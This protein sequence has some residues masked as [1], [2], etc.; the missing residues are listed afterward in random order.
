MNVLI[1]GLKGTVSVSE[2]GLVKLSIPETGMFLT[3]RPPQKNMSCLKKTVK[4]ILKRAES[5]TDDK[6]L[7]T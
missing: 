5:L 1:N 4:K 3:E 6:W 7:K 2:T